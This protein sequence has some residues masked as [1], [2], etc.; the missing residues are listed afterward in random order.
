MASRKYMDNL[1]GGMARSAPGSFAVEKTDD[2]DNL[3]ADAIEAQRAGMSYGQ[4]K[5]LHPYTKELREAAYDKKENVDNAIFCK[6]CGGAYVPPK[7]KR[8]GQ[9]CSDE[10]REAAKRERERAR[11]A[12]N[13]G[14]GNGELHP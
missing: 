5:A 11:N 4:Y 8:K 10:C 13:G 14:Q 2:M 6:H 7:D 9:Y 1:S 3:S 12:A